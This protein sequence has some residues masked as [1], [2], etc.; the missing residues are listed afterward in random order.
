M[1]GQEVIKPE[2]G[3]HQDNIQKED[4]SEHGKNSGKEVKAEQNNEP[5]TSS[6]SE[7]DC[8]VVYG[9]QAT[10]KVKLRVRVIA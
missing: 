7:S 8:Q 5:C 3:S 9:I 6:S 4:V 2:N 10:F 1:A